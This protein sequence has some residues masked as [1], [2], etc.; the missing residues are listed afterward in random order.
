MES[1]QEMHFGGEEKEECGKEECFHMNHPQ[2][3]VLVLGVF[4]GARE[5]FPPAGKKGAK[6]LDRDS[7]PDGPFCGGPY[8]LTLQQKLSS[9]FT[10]TRCG[11]GLGKR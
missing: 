9:T 7:V 3:G 11:F 6:P 2:A 10:G 8:S 1:S 5:A 4:L